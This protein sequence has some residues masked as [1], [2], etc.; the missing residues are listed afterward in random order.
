MFHERSYP[1]PCDL[2]TSLCHPMPGLM[3]KGLGRQRDA[4]LSP[5]RLTLLI[6][7]TRWANPPLITWFKYTLTSE[8][9]MVSVSSQA[10]RLVFFSPPLCW[11][12][13]KA[14]PARL[15]RLV[16][17]KHRASM[18]PS[19]SELYAAVICRISMWSLAAHPAGLYEGAC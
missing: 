14:F 1:Q 19:A 12:P 15:R 11:E 8:S 3:Q 13:A 5:N 16:V 9:T 7:S 2:W 6:H 17:R 10:G 18:I 4:Q